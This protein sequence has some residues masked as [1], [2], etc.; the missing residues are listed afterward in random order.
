L[1]APR[2]VKPDDLTDEIIR[3]HL[4]WILAGQYKLGEG[5]HAGL[6]KRE[7]LRLCRAA[8]VP[9]GQRVVQAWWHAREQVAASINVRRMHEAA[10]DH[11]VEIGDEV[12]HS[13]SKRTG[14]VV[15]FKVTH[16]GHIEALVA[17]S[18]PAIE[19]SWWHLVRCVKITKE[20]GGAV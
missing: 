16:D 6:D 9:D 13:M 18:P 11:G 1:I 7:A 19:E 5:P 17:I 2:V 12:V 14:R 8:L 4:A 3:E 20:D 15:E 10:R